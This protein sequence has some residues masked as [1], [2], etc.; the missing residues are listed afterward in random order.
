[1]T[2]ASASSRETIG[3]TQLLGAGRNEELRNLHLIQVPSHREVSGRP[4]GA[5]HEVDIVPLDQATCQVERNG[6]IRIVVV[7]NETN[8]PAINSARSR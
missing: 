4:E 3:I 2:V 5:E 7:G 1:M 8:L 6:G